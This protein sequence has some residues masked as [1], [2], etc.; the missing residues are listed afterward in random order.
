MNCILVGL[1]IGITGSGF[2]ALIAWI[3]PGF[4]ERDAKA[5]IT[6]EDRSIPILRGPF[7]SFRRVLSNL[8]FYFLIVRVVYTGITL[9]LIGYLIMLLQKNP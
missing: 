6:S 4:I 3:N 2:Y 1:V 5:Q 9:V 8:P 7:L